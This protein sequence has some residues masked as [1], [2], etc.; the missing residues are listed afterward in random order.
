MNDNLQGWWQTYCGAG[1][2]T[3]VSDLLSETHKYWIYGGDEYTRLKYYADNLLPLEL[4]CAQQKVRLQPLICHVLVLLVGYSMEPL[5]QAISVFAPREKIVLLVNQVY[6]KVDERGNH[7]QV[8]GCLYGADVKE[9]VEELLLPKVFASELKPAIE[10]HVIGDMAFS[11][12]LLDDSATITAGSRMPALVFQTLCAHVLPDHRDHKKVV[13]DITGGKK[14]MDVGAFLFAAYTDIPVSYVDFEK[15]HPRHRRPYGYTC[16]VS[17]LENPYTLF[18]LPGWEEVRSLFE[19]YHFRGAREVLNRVIDAMRNLFTP[20]QIRSAQRL[21]Q[22]LDLYT[23]WDDGDYA[24]ARCINDQ[25]QAWVKEL[26]IATEQDRVC[27]SPPPVLN[28]PQPTESHVELK[29]LPV[30]RDELQNWQNQR[31]SIDSDFLMSNC[32]LLAYAR[33]ELEKIQRLANQNED[34]RSALLRAMG[35]EELL[36]KARL[37][38]LWEEGLVYLSNQHKTSREQLDPFNQIWFETLLYHSGNTEHWRGTL[39][40]I[41]GKYISLAF[42]YPLG[43]RNRFNDRIRTDRTRAPRLQSYYIL[44]DCENPF[45]AEVLTDLRN[46]AI[47]KYQYV[48]QEI[49]NTALA[50]VKANLAEFETITNGWLGLAA[51]RTIKYEPTTDPGRL[52]WETIRRLCGLDFLPF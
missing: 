30:A 9:W 23:A 24:E 6:D 10:V 18:A 25:I 50:L 42:E 29:A 19:K 36:L 47:H 48:D 1:P 11:G 37:V 5:F 31:V 16:H 40:K 33:D 38:R 46:Q 34:N 49:A 32:Q 27:F 51:D 4:C 41:E 22:I 52:D 12:P 14:S 3:G 7:V 20:A 28:S 39:C 26:P 45:I 17:R 2:L 8:E 13:I 35:L 44:K 15:Y 21:G 43:S